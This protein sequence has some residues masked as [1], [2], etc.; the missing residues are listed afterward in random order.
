MVNSI[1]STMKVMRYLLFIVFFVY[2]PGSLADQTNLPQLFH[3]VT[4]LETESPSIFSDNLLEDGKTIMNEGDNAKAYVIH[5]YLSMLAT[6]TKASYENGHLQ[7]GHAKLAL[8]NEYFAIT[9]PRLDDWLDSALIDLAQT[10]FLRW[11]YTGEES[12]KKEAAEKFMLAE[13]LEIEKEKTDREPA[14]GHYS[15]KHTETENEARTAPLTRR[16]LA[17]AQ[18]IS[19]AAY[20][21]IAMYEDA[22]AIRAKRGAS[23]DDLVN[24]VEEG[25]EVYRA[26]NERLQPN[27]L[28]R[29]YLGLLSTAD[30]YLDAQHFE[31]FAPEYAVNA[32]PL[33][34]T[35]YQVKR[36]KNAFAKVKELVDSGELDK[37]VYALDEYQKISIE[38]IRGAYRNKLSMDYY[39]RQCPAPKTAHPV[40][41]KLAAHAP[42]KMQSFQDAICNSVKNVLT[43]DGKFVR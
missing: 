4:K 27:T 34:T 39:H 42:E 24:I 12:Y 23:Q 36:T 19:H 33:S 2:F 14:A 41:A 5:S 20:Q 40:F 31:R 30:I 13:K 25:L 6:S 17:R 26:A 16:Q 37:A 15:T 8:M 29:A 43:Q 9:K 38:N 21:H 28:R 3:Q 35:H 18:S 7:K 10:E 22:I 11:I 32:G 1:S